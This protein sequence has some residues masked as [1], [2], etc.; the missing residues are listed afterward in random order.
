MVGWTRARARQGKAV[1]GT[2][3]VSIDVRIRQRIIFVSGNGF[4]TLSAVSTASVAVCILRPLALLTALF[5]FGLL[6]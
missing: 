6:L 3:K 2:E 5:P 4:G 1:R